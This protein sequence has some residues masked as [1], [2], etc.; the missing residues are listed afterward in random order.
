MSEYGQ[1]CFL[2]DWFSASCVLDAGT[3][4]TDMLPILG[5]EKCDPESFTDGWGHH[6][7]KKSR[8]NLGIRIYYDFTD[9]D[10]VISKR[11]WVEM[12]GRGCRTFETLS[13]K[14]FTDLFK[15]CVPAAPDKDPVFARVSRIDLAFDIFDNPFI[16]D[17]V[18]AAR[19]SRSIVSL[20]GVSTLCEGETLTP[21]GA[22]ANYTE[23]TIYF[24][25]MKSDIYMRLYDKKLER[26]RSDIDSWYRW[27]I[28]FKNSNA[29][30][31]IQ[32]YLRDYY[33]K[34]EPVGRMF[35]TYLN[36]YISI[37][38]YNPSDTNYRRWNVSSWWETFTSGFT[39]IQKLS[40]RKIDYNMQ[41]VCDLTQRVYGNTIDTILRTKGEKAL[42][43]LIKSRA[44]HLNDAQLHLIA[45]FKAGE[46]DEQERAENA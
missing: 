23:R 8:S 12:S 22:A 13:T 33:C 7:Y 20:F 31:L 40:K 14:T 28:V 44:T 18:K 24:G 11:Y 19:A 27:E 42:I 38:D 15:L 5:L 6:G 43:D 4:W 25:S 16:F 39:T 35:Y 46:R 10:N 36:K 45:E 29:L 26:L 32:T 17:R 34:S 3:D 2:I 1:N 21:G 30:E 41:H 9:D 37:R